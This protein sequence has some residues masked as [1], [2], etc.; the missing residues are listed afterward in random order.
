MCFICKDDVV[1]YN[2]AKQ[3]PTLFNFLYELQVCRA[4]FGV[5]VGVV[6]AEN[7]GGDASF[8][9]GGEDKFETTQAYSWCEMTWKLQAQMK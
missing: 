2:Y 6:V 1:Q 3:F 5:A 7:E 8:D 4:W 9:C